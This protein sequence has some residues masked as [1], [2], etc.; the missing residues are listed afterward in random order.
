[1]DILKNSGLGLGVGLGFAVLALS[2]LGVPPGEGAYRCMAVFAGVGGILGALAS[3]RK[4]PSP[5]G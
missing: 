4:P 5:Q 1:M 3:F 2:I